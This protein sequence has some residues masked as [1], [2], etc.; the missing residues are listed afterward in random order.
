[1]LMRDGAGIISSVTLGPDARTQILP[2]T[3]NALFAIYAPV[4]VNEENVRAHFSAIERNVRLLAP[5]ATTVATVLI[6]AQS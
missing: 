3:T 5:D 1:M 6:T 2:A 4:G